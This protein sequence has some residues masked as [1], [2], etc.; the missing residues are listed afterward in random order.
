[1]RANE[2]GRIINIASVH[3]LVASEHKAGYISA[4]HGLIGLTKTVALETATE[5][6][7]CN[8]ISPGFVRTQLIESQIQTKAEKMDVS[9][10]T[11]ATMI[12]QDKQPSLN[13]VEPA[14]IASLVVFLCSDAATQITGSTFTMDG[15]WTA[16]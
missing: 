15:G 8:A 3:G 14:D 5:P 2:F 11:A 7:T 4:K 9:I 13:F 6:V 1:M 16:Q 10:D 12:L